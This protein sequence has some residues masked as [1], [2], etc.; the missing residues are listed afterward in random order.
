MGYLAY[1]ADGAA[2][3][4]A[5]SMASTDEG[6]SGSGPA[7]RGGQDTIP[8]CAPQLSQLLALQALRQG[9]A[10]VR[11]RIAGLAGGCVRACVISVLCAMRCS[12]TSACR[13]AGMFPP[14]PP[15]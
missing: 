14:H 12:A 8:I 11:E 7:G 1:P 9:Q 13:P 2:L 3:P 10:Y 4:S 5:T 6:G 15:P